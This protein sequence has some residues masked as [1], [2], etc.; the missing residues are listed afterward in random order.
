MLVILG[1]LVGIVVITRDDAPTSGRAA[2]T[3]AAPMATTST[4]T[5]PV[6]PVEQPPYVRCQDEVG[7]APGRNQTVEEH[8]QELNDCLVGYGEEPLPPTPPYLAPFR[9]AGD[10]VLVSGT[11]HIE[12]WNLD[13]TYAWDGP[14]CASAEWQKRSPG[15]EPDIDVARCRGQLIGVDGATGEERWRF[16][17][18]LEAYRTIVGPT[19]L[20]RLTE[21]EVVVNDLATGQQRWERAGAS[22][23]FGD[24]S[25]AV[26]DVNVYVA[27]GS[28]VHALDLATGEERWVHPGEA[29][30]L[31][32]ANGAVIARRA[33]GHL[34]RLDP[35]TG[36]VAWT[37]AAQLG[38]RQKRDVVAF[39]EAA[40]IVQD[41]W[42]APVTAFDLAT[43]ERRWA[44]DPDGNVDFDTI[45]ADPTGTAVAFRNQMS[46][47]VEVA[48]EADG[49]AT[50]S[51]PLPGCAKQLALADGLLVVLV[52]VEETNERR[53]VVLPSR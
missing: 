36:E 18:A 53:V 50:A 41:D 29:V 38:D 20:V 31:G 30:G 28:G 17:A 4:T 6:A 27:N 52:H 16:D 13:G 42:A 1:S 8:D 49:N 2:P 5:G 39:S 15:A 12:G 21:D 48:T 26:D 40:V 32:A 34:V 23:G 25:V 7:G 44:H 3:T 14:D 33:D 45:V 9:I 11:D 43:G 22:D 24:G 19:T 46:C 35:L 37:A 47:T 10:H 51:P